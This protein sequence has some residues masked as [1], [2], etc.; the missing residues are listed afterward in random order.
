MLY[1]TVAKQNHNETRWHKRKGNPGCIYHGLIENT[2]PMQHQAVFLHPHWGLL[3]D[4]CHTRIYISPLT[5]R[6]QL[7]PI[8]AFI[9][10]CPVVKFCR[11]SMSGQAAAGF[12][13]IS[14]KSAHQRCRPEAEQEAR[15][16]SREKRRQIMTKGLSERCM[17]FI[18]THI[19]K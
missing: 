2:L 1:Y 7:S 13:L 6:G 18:L 9:G 12:H 8:S 15:W 17:D 10:S 3:L 5:A 11:D 14:V 4:L 16:Y 19:F